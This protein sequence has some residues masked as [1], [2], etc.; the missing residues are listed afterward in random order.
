MTTAVRMSLSPSPSSTAP[1]AM[2]WPPVIWA[3]LIG[4][5]VCRAAGFAFP[6]LSFRL[7]ELGH[8][9]QLIGRTLAVFGFGWLVGQ[10]LC[11]WLSDRIGRRSTLIG[12]LLAATAVLPVLAT[13]EST[14]AVVAA[15]ALVGVVYDSHRP[16]V[17]ATI[18]DQIPTEA[19]RT[20]VSGW[21]H[22]AV[23]VGAAVTGAV[24]GMLAADT[25]MGFLFILNAVACGFFA[26]IAAVFMPSDKR[27]APGRHVRS[28][29]RDAARDGRLWLVCLASLC[30]LTACAAMFSSL[31]M[32]MTLDR[33]DAAAY[34]WTQVAAAAVVVLLTP[35]LMPYLGRR[36]AGPS[37]MVGPFALSSVILGVGM[38]A[39]GLTSTTLGYSLA[40]G[41]AV[42][43]E[44]I[45]FVAASDLIHRISPPGAR[46]LYA[47][48]WGAQLAL[49]VIIAP[50]LSAWAISTGGGLLAAATTLGAGLLGAVLCV[51]LR[52][53]LPHAEVHEPLPIRP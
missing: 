20:L 48:V 9:P 41:F 31:P 19:G 3:L 43:G 34:G 35:L 36:A 38:G 12:A 39:T 28:S 6:F 52:A 53:L 13:A 1:S 44:V 25:G 15:A 8:S 47:G 21:R 24:G 40:V 14:A 16:I 10:L 33:L 4:T 42:T 46:G 50:L 23:N 2:R 37:A 17:S 49:A 32:L 27:P 26:L 18:Q 22:F 45:L 11:G 51:P 29:Y 30:A 5:F 7:V